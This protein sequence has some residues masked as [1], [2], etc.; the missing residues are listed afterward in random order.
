MP[1]RRPAGW[2]LLLAAAVVLHT[3]AAPFAKVEE[4]FNLQATHDLLFHGTN[5][6]AYDHLE[7]PGVVPRTFLGAAAVAAAA[8]PIVAPLRLLGAP[9][10][11]AQIAARLVLVRAAAG[12]A[13]RCPCVVHHKLACARC[14]PTL[15][16]LHSRTPCAPPVPHLAGR[17]H[18][19][20]AG[21]A[22]A[23][24]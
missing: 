4:S 20:L 8:A 18:R 21:A 24:D 11:A 22:A 5:L 19:G 7:F 23:C 15:S 16:V 13:W 12:R 17:P 3:L 9:K 6:T 10:L 14:P 1:P 2:T